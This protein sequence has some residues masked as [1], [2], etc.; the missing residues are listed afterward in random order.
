MK[1]KLTMAEVEA[2]TML[3]GIA[4]SCQ[5]PTDSTE[6]TA[7]YKKNIDIV[8]SMTTKMS[9]DVHDKFSNCCG[10]PILEDIM[11]CSLCL[12]HCEEEVEEEVEDEA[13]NKASNNKGTLI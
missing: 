9:W 11:I 5:K 7:M 1:T 6:L 2:I 4:K 3:I 12:E 8:S 13:Y 10:E